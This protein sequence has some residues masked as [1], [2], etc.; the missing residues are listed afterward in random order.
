M[1]NWKK[2][3]ICVLI[4][5]LITSFV[6]LEV[7]KI[8]TLHVIDHISNNS[9]EYEEVGK[10]LGENFKNL[11]FNISQNVN[12][13]FD[14]NEIEPTTED[15][16][17]AYQ[18]Y[19]YINSLNVYGIYY[20]LLISGAIIGIM[21]YFIFVQQ[22]KL[23]NLLLLYIIS[24]TVW[25]GLYY[26]ITVNSIGFSIDNLLYCSIGYTVSIILCYIINL[27]YRKIVT[28]NE[29]CEKFLLKY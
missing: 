14:K 27:C 22:T 15:I 25:V 11:T 19:A 26:L 3:L 29:K 5:M 21:I 17:I 23:T 24:F 7:Y 6:G 18:I 4:S 13:N 16:G 2:L 9:E 12:E 8:Y 10:I 28:N 20:M 1:K